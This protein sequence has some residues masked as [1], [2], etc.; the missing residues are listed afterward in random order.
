MFY[1]CKWASLLKNISILSTLVNKFFLCTIVI[2]RTCPWKMTLINFVHTKICYTKCPFTKNSTTP[3]FF[4]VKMLDTDST[5]LLLIALLLPKRSVEMQMQY[6]Y[7][8]VTWVYL[9]HYVP[10][11]PIL[12]QLLWLLLVLIGACF[13]FSSLFYCFVISFCVFCLKQWNK[14]PRNVWDCIFSF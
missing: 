11:I 3:K 8:D 9:Y 2:L 13:S 4:D 12:A 5:Y 14:D 10:E 1:D 6:M 7:S